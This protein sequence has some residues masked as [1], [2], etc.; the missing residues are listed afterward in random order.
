[1]IVGLRCPACNKCLNDAELAV[2]DETDGFCSVCDSFAQ[3]Y[4]REIDDNIAAKKQDDEFDFGDVDLSIFDS[5][6]DE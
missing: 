3:E 1:M 4:G 2:Y 5:I 6:E